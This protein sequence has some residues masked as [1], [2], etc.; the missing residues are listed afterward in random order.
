MQVSLDI[1]PP[2]LSKIHQCCNRPISLCQYPARVARI[3]KDIEIP[4]HSSSEFSGDLAGSASANEIKITGRALQ[5]KI[6][7]CPS[8]QVKRIIG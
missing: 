1:L 8:N 3:I 6:T 5:K 7:H 4:I 2:Q